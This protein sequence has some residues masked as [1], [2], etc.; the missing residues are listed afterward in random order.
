MWLLE[1]PSQAVV[2]ADEGTHSHQKAPHS[3]LQGRRGVAAK[4]E[5]VD[6][7]EDAIQPDCACGCPA[8]LKVQEAHLL[9]YALQIVG[10]TT[11]KFTEERSVP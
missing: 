4:D 2:L 9:G 7:L 1:P 6:D 11:C 10:S 8:V 3:R 5:G